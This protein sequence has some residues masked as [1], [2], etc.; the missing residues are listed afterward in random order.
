MA[1]VSISSVLSGSGV[2]D[3]QWSCLQYRVDNGDKSFDIKAGN[4]YIYVNLPKQ[5]SLLSIVCI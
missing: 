4:V 2:S 5:R 1:N 3:K